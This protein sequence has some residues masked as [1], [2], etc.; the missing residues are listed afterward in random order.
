MNL[1]LLFFHLLSLHI[2]TLPRCMANLSSFYLFS[3]DE[4]PSIVDQMIGHS[5]VTKQTATDGV[6]VRKVSKSRR[7]CATFL[8]LSNTETETCIPEKYTGYR[9][10]L[11]TT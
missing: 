7:S 1:Q 3:Y 4:I 2:S 8:L 10:L 6:L 9:P 5:L 11:V